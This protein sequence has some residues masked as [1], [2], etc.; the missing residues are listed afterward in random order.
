MDQQ[1]MST[2]LDK[3][4]ELKSHQQGIIVM[5][6]ELCQRA[7]RIAKEIEKVEEEIRFDSQA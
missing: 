6:E 1:L 7:E 5:L 4:T 3:I 2:T